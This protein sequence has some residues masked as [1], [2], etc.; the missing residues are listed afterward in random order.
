MK[1][2]QGLTGEVSDHK[3]LAVF[4]DVRRAV[5]HA[6]NVDLN[7]HGD[8]DR[9]PESHRTCVYRVVHSSVTPL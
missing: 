3:V 6:I 8:F 4:E 2:E 7:M 1:H 9:L 5:Y